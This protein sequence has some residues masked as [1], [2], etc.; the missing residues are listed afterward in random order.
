[1]KI[2]FNNARRQA[3]I[4]YDKLVNE[5]SESDTYEGYLLVDPES[6]EERL[7]DLRMMIGSVAMTFEEGNEDFKD[8]YQELYPG[9]KSMAEFSAESV[10]DE[11]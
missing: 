9:D 2:N 3:C 8:V 11:D 1:M 7:N 5:L 10:Q 4:A 6:L